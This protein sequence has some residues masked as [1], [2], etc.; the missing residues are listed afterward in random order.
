VTTRGA[1]GLNGL[2]PLTPLP[3]RASCGD[4]AAKLE[5]LRRSPVLFGRSSSRSFSSG[6]S[7][8]SEGLSRRFFV[9]L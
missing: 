9:L 8:S 7:L 3:C 4:D 1:L 2:P 6:D 5:L